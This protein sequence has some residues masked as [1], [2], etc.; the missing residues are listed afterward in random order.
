MR[1]FMAGAAAAALMMSG[2]ATVTTASADPG[3]RV[4]HNGGGKGHHGGKHYRGHRY[5]GHRG[6]RYYDRGWDN[7]DNW[8]AAV[9]AGVIGAA[10]GVI[11]GSALANSSQ[12]RVVQTVPSGSTHAQRCAAQY[13]SYDP[14]TDTYVTYG[15][16]VRRCPL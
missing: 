1:K 13:R 8:G 15:G 11:A 6:A 4:Y 5:D 10:A 12:P 14:R 7:D 3:P 2:V 16:D 9:G